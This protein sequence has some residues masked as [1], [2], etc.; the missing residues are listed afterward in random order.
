MKAL[1]VLSCVLN[2]RSVMN[3][4]HAD[5]LSVWNASHVVYPSLYVANSSAVLLINKNCR[6]RKNIDKNS[7]VTPTPYFYLINR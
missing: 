1:H 5:Q 3:T 2:G 7:A 4:Q 6:F